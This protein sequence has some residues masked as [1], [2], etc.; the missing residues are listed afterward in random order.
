MCIAMELGVF[1]FVILFSQTL[2][3]SNPNGYLQARP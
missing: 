3:V 1:A 2:N